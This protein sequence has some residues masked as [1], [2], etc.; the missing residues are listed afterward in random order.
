VDR[1][2]GTRESATDATSLRQPTLLRVAVECI[3]Q[4][5]QENRMISKYE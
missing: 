2:N 4:H 1:F 3:Y 5:V